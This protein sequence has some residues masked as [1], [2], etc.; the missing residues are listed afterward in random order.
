[1]NEDAHGTSFKTND[2]GEKKM[3][4]KV[5]LRVLLSRLMGL[6]VAQRAL[7]GPLEN[8]VEDVARLAERFS[9]GRNDV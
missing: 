6:L 8:L 4:T 1:M 9:E 7:A 5:E 3:T 2:T